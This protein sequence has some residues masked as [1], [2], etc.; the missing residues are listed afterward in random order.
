MLSPPSSAGDLEYLRI[1]YGPEYLMPENLERLRSRGL[2]AKRSLASRE[3]ALGEA[4]QIR[5]SEKGA[6][7]P[8]QRRYE[9]MP[10]RLISRSN[11][12]IGDQLAR[13]AA[14]GAALHRNS[15]HRG[16][17][18]CTVDIMSKSFDKNA[19]CCA[20][21]YDASRCEASKLGLKIRR[22]LPSVGVQVPLR[23]PPRK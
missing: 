20:M 16:A 13:G 9:R 15:V 22:R 7:R 11:S 10:S 18:L 21:R 1:I 5:G 3:F 6:T 8:I 2:G 4:A 12:G 23:A 17:I 14:F 19:L